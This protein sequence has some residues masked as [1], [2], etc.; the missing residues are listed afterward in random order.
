MGSGF[1]KK[2]MIILPSAE[3]LSPKKKKKSIKKVKK[4][5]VEEQVE[6]LLQ[7]TP[8]VFSEPRAVP[9]PQAIQIIEVEETTT[10]IRRK[11]KKPS[12]KKKEKPVAVINEESIKIMPE[13]PVTL[14]EVEKILRTNSKKDKKKLDREEKKKKKLMELI[15]VDAANQ[16]LEEEQ[17]PQANTLPK[18]TKKKTIKKVV[19]KSKKDKSRQSNDRFISTTGGDISP[20]QTNKPADPIDPR[21]ESNESSSGVSTMNSLETPERLNSTEKQP[22]SALDSINAILNKQLS[23]KGKKKSVKKAQKNQA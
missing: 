13:Q 11:K 6:T 17:K 19:R 8:R 3:K 12:V 4:Q 21:R 10:T 2:P 14:H 22:E 5:Q 16:V 1:E 18:T 23:K 9:K 20:D 15:G 7:P